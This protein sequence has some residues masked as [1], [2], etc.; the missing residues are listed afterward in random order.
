V[1]SPKREIG[2]DADIVVDSPHSLTHHSLQGEIALSN[3][4]SAPATP[5]PPAIFFRDTG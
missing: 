2:P 1:K 4:V 5:A 3:T